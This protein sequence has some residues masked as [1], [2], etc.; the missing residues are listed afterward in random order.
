MLDTVT[1][2]V[3]NTL[4]VHE[5][6]DDKLRN[7][8]IDSLLRALKSEGADICRDDVVRAYDRSEDHLKSLWDQERDLGLEGHLKL[9]LE[10]L[11]LPESYRDAIREPYAKILLQF[12]PKPVD[13]AAELLKELK[14]KG[15]RIGLIS[16]TGRTP[17]ETMKIV[18]EGYAMLQ[19]FDAMSFSCDVGHIKPGRHIFEMTLKDLKAKPGS[20]VHVGDSML[21]DIYGA[22]MA[23]MKAVLFNKY[24]EGFE[25]YA[26][27]YYNANGRHQE[28]D[29]VVRELPEVERAL[30]QLGGK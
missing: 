15:Y 9:L 4:L 17:G 19:Y 5:F 27:R 23:G 3:W 16:N 7:A 8:R 12:K 10:C 25:Q 14:E 2:D 1:F 24:S 11:G 20:S 22:K 26:S 29:A 30:Q 28:P 6:Y 21:L 18:L 13:G